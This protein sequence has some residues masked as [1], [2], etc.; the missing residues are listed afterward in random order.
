MIIHTYTHMF[1]KLE[2][3]FNTDGHGNTFFMS[4]KI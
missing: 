3:V 2:V 1:I 4:L